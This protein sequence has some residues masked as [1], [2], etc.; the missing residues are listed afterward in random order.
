MVNGEIVPGVRIGNCCIGEQKSIIMGLFSDKYKVWDRGDGFS[1]YTYGNLKLWFNT[2]GTLCQIGVS[3][4]FTGKYLTIGIGSTMQDV[5]DCF[6][7]YRNDGD[8]YYIP[9]VDGL[10]FE[11][12]DV[13]DWNELTAPIEWIYVYEID[14]NGQKHIVNSFV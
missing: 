1:V 3:S 14:V 2:D 11:L 12:E 5:V 10:C 8:E 4:G 9:N 13:E 7:G 6:G